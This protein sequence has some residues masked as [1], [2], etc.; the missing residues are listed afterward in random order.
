M[1]KELS[2]SNEKFRV[3][4]V[5][6]YDLLSD[7][8][9]SGR[10]KEIKSKA[11]RHGQAIYLMVND[12]NDYVWLVRQIELIGSFL[13]EHPETKERVIN[14][15]IINLQRVNKYIKN[16]TDKQ[17]LIKRIVDELLK[18]RYDKK[19]IDSNEIK[20]PWDRS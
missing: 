5:Y 20:M 14:L 18:I 9:K 16:E 15:L 1:E 12:N 13:H 10:I 17:A 11:W 3:G 19:E 7:L 6:T 2:G 4:R 8:L